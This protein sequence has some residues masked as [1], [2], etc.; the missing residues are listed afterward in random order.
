MIFFGVFIETGFLF[1]RVKVI[2]RVLVYG[3]ISCVF[4]YL[5]TANHTTSHN[6]VFI[7]KLVQSDPARPPF[8]GDTLGFSE[9][10]ASEFVTH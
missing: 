10:M 3:F 6:K 8:V 4:I 7:P 9:G 5:K 2:S 1:Q